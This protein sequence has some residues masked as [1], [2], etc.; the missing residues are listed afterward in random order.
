[1]TSSCKLKTKY[2][3]GNI[4]GKELKGC[5]EKRNQI[6]SPF[7]CTERSATVTGSAV[8]SKDVKGGF[9]L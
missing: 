7:S 5:I 3:S 6:T 4:K 1:M 2:M 9:F 8:L